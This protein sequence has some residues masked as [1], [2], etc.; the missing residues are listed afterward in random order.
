MVGYLFSSR[1]RKLC[2]CCANGCGWS[3]LLA[4]YNGSRQGV[5]RLRV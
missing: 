2:V 3:F 4:S 5:P 1:H